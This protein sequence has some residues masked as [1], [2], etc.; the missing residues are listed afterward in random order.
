MNAATHPLF[1]TIFNQR[2]VFTRQLKFMLPDVKTAHM[3]RRAMHHAN[4]GNED[5]RY[6]AKA[7]ANLGYLN[8]AGKLERSRLHLDGSF[9]FFIG[10]AL[11]YLSAMLLN[12][13]Y[14]SS[15]IK[16]RI[17]SGEIMMIVSVPFGR[18]QRSEGS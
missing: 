16:N 12:K 14:K 11:G 6:V 18:D 17:S 5:I 1:H 10:T 13:A 15:D 8:K 2:H 4:I 7:S 9:G 3:A